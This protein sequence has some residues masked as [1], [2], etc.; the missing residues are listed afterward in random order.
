MVLS[1]FLMANLTCREHVYKFNQTLF[2]MWLI[3]LKVTEGKLLELLSHH[4]FL[5]LTDLTDTSS[6]LI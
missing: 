2:N 6:Q 5:P 1:L 3:F 4:H